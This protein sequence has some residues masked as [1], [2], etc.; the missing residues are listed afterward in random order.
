VEI[1]IVVSENIRHPFNWIKFIVGFFPRRGIKIC[2]KIRGL[3]Y[4]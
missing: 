2:N 4:K 1:V 3:D